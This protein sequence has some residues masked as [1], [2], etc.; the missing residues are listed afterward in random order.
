M[1]TLAYPTI[2]APTVSV[3]LPDVERLP[4]SRPLRLRQRILETDAGDIIVYD[5]GAQNSTFT[6]RVSPISKTDADAIMAFFKNPI[7][8][9]GVNGRAAMFEF[10][11]TAAVTRTV[12]FAMDVLQ[13]QQRSP[14]AWDVSLTLR[15]E[16][17]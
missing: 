4:L 5:F 14:N 11:D 9:G 3:S 15:E 6:V 7:G 1:I 17:P 12:R 16:I 10:K 2:A 13:P 8:S